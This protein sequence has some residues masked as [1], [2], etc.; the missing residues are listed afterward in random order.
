M[1]IV[2]LIHDITQLSNWYEV[3]FAQDFEGMLR[4][5]YTQELDKDF[6]EHEHL[7]YPDCPPEKLEQEVIRS[8]TE[9]L[10]KH[11]GEKHYG[12]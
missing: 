7:G 3:K 12:V 2:K 5:D 11:K 10:E 1:N 9:F 4:V 6:Y 8:L